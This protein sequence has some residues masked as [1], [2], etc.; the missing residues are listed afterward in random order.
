MVLSVHSLRRILEP[1]WVTQHRNTPPTPAQPDP[2]DWGLRAL[3]ALISPLTTVSKCCLPVSHLNRQ[4]Y[5]FHEV[6]GGNRSTRTQLFICARDR[7]SNI[8]HIDINPNRTHALPYRTAIQVVVIEITHSPNSTGGD[9]D[10]KRDTQNYSYS[11]YVE[12]I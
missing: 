1:S 10:P 5:A 12:T 4:Q 3:L 11:E 9:Y 8:S 7:A 6:S 2:S